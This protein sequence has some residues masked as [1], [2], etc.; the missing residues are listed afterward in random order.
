MVFCESRALISYK[1]PG[2]SNVRRLAP[3]PG[4]SAEGKQPMCLRQQGI[5][6]LGECRIHVSLVLTKKRALRTDRASVR[7]GIDGKLFKETLLLIFNW[8][9]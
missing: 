9:Y 8:Q 6:K 7:L 5:Q 2:E 3:G 4:R 1:R